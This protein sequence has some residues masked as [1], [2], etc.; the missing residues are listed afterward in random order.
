MYIGFDAKCLK[1]LSS[2]WYVLTLNCGYVYTY[3]VSI[4]CQSVYVHTHVLNIRVASSE[5]QR[6]GLA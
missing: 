4:S 2:A 1:V 6:V 5:W 3:T